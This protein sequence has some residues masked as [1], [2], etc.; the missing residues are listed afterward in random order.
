MV[1]RL[2]LGEL[3][4]GISWGIVQE[5]FLCFLL[6]PPFTTPPRGCLYIIV[7]ARLLGRMQLDEEFR[8]VSVQKYAGM[9]HVH[10]QIVDV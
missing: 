1:S 3:T 6:Q 8:V 9:F 7:F 4:A 5:A 2:C 10:W